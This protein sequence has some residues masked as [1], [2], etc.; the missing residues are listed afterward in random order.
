MQKIKNILLVDDDPASNFLAQ[1]LL[2]EFGF[3]EEN[4]VV[5]SNG[6]EAIDYILH[7]CNSKEIPDLIFLDINMPVMDG[8]E[9]LDEFKTVPLLK[10][11]K[12]VLLTSSVSARD[13]DKAK[14]YVLFDYINKP[15]TEEKLHKILEE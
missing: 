5:K 12:I 14:E 11:V 8:F 13:Y 15:L 6:K 7:E 3:T 9:F 1:L 4:V 10:A 2:E